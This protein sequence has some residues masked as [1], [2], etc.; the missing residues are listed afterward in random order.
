MKA[1][2]TRST[3]GSASHAASVAYPVR[4][5]RNRPRS[6]NRLHTELARYQVDDAF[7]LHPVKPDSNAPPGKR[8]CRFS[9]LIKG[10]AQENGEAAFRVL[11]HGE[12]LD[13]RQIEPSLLHLLK[14]L[15]CKLV[16]LTTEEQ[17][18]VLFLRW[19]RT[20]VLENLQTEGFGAEALGRLVG[21]GPAQLTRK[22]QK[23]ACMH[24]SAFIHQVRIEEACHLLKTTCK[25]VNEVAYEVGYHY[26]ANFSNKFKEAVGITPRE[27]VRKCR[28]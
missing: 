1:P 10:N 16:H 20:H 8:G 13:L 25:R 26:P 6:T 23:Y 3:S 28:A 9:L 17:Q 24:P 5:K 2:P 21:F 19:L 18:Q 12:T 27:F 4:K 11:H 7:N 15:L 14:D 22:I